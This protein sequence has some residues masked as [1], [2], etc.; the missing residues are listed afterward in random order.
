MKPEARD[1]YM[2]C[3]YLMSHIQELKVSFGATKDTKN[4]ACVSDPQWLLL[5]LFVCGIFK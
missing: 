2:A 4:A 3:I 1:V 5:C